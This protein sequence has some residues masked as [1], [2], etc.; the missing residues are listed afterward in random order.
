MEA[1]TSALCSPGAIFDLSPLCL[2]G[3]TGLHMRISWGGLSWPSWAATRFCCCWK[4]SGL[5]VHLDYA[6]VR[7]CER[8]C[9]LPCGHV[10]SS[11]ACG[12]GEKREEMWGGEVR[13]VWTW[14]DLSLRSLRCILHMP[15]EAF[16]ACHLSATA[17]LLSSTNKTNTHTYAHKHTHCT[18]TSTGNTSATHNYSTNKHPRGTQLCVG[19]QT[20]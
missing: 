12:R 7:K 1:G 2:H 13:C 11:V 14:R 15:S 20:H 6:Q 10:V 19:T 5:N 16:E 18:E 8:V 17:G 3:H 9:T 4:E